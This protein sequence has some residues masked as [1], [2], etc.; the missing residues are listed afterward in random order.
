M[1]HILYLSCGIPFPVWTVQK[2]YK[3]NYADIA[4]EEGGG[5]T[6]VHTQ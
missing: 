6:N 5:A 4:A 3:E 2:K 1:P